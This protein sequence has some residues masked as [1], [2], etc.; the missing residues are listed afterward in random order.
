MKKTV[1]IFL[2]FASLALAEQVPKEVQDLIHNAFTGTEKTTLTDFNEWKVRMGFDSSTKISDILP[3]NPIKKYWIVKDSILNANENTPMSKLMNPIIGEYEVPL[4]LKKNKD[5]IIAF[6]I[7]M[8]NKNFEGKWHVAG[9]S[10]GG[11][12][13]TEWQRVIK[14]W[15][16][17]SGYNPAIIEVPGLGFKRFL[18]VPEKG[19]DNL[20]YLPLQKYENDSF[21]ILPDSSYSTLTDRKESYKSIRKEFE[22]SRLNG[23]HSK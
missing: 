23:G 19:E 15:P 7:L 11:R 6:L 8:K 22:A 12:L 13:A 20:T 4:F 14:K 9:E 21:A 18:H 17:S 10:A 16:Q 5:K 2:L 1:L 3:G